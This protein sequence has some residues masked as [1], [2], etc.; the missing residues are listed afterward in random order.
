MSFQGNQGEV[1]PL[2]GVG[3]EIPGE[4]DGAQLV[5][6]TQI[7]IS[8]IV[9]NAVSQAL[10]H[11]TLT[12][13]QQFQTPIKFD[14]PAFEGDSTASWLTWSQ[15]VV[16]QARASGFENEL[17]ATVGDGLSV[18]ADVFDSSNVDPVRLRNAH[19]AWMI[20]INS[21]SGMALEIVQRSD[22]PNDAW[23]NLEFH[24]REKGTR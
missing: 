24:Y 21:C 3:H 6:L 18:G 7:Q 20:L 9:S 19:A 13:A 17:T 2:V 10:T 22:A 12:A 4:D 15:R 14:V 5:Q 11:Q 23:R 8:Q 1:D 16:Y